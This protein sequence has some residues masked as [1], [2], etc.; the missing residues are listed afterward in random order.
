MCGTEAIIAGVAIASVAISAAGTGVSLY[1]Q[2]EQADA[3]ANYQKR[4]AEA[5]NQ[6]IA[7]NFKLA[8]ASAENQNKALQA[9]AVQE[10][11][12]A[13]EEKMRNAREAAKAVATA[14]VA[15]GEGGVSGNSV[16]ALLNDFMAQEAR[17]RHSVNVNL[18]YARDSI[19][20]EQE[21]D[22]LVAKGRAA[23]I[24]PFKPSPIQQPNYLAGAL[25]IAGS[26][27][28]AYAG[29]RKSSPNSGA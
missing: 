29:Y 15:A 3:E 18:E 5:R 21:S 13:T 11:E 4:L 9:R 14:R 17:Y 7:E 2:S 25:K 27:L 12:A 19:E 6:E 1:A 16:N 26:G 10:G 28:E 23:S 8:V 20:Y 24:K 22:H